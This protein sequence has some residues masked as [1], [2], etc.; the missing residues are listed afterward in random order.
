[1][2]ISVPKIKE[3]QLLV[4]LKNSGIKYAVVIGKVI[5]AEDHKIFI[6]E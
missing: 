6:E 4:E 3:K 5:R 1:M 2:L